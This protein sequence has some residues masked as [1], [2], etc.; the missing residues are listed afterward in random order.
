[1]RIT[2]PLRFFYSLLIGVLV[3]SGFGLGATAAMIVALVVFA[4]STVASR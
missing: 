3:A 1:M 4:A 2:T